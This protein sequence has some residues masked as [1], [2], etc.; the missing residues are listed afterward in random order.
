[1][2]PI[3]TLSVLLACSIAGNVFAVLFLSRRKGSERKPDQTAAELLQDLTQYG[4][5]LVRLE[6]I[7]PN[8]VLL[9]GSRR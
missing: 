5:A 8:D 2:L 7:S 4:N 6:R 1:M 3:V 9:R